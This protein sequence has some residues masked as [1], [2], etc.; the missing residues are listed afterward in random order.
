MILEYENKENKKEKG[1]KLNIDK[2]KENFEDFRNYFNNKNDKYLITLSEKTGHIN[3]VYK[4][5]EKFNQFLSKYKPEL[6]KKIIKENKENNGEEDSDTKGVQM[7]KLS[8]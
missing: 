3:F 8:F 1:Q 7:F 4:D 6:E 5:K 2:M